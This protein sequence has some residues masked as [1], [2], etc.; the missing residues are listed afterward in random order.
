MLAEI[1]LGEEERDEIGVAAFDVEGEAEGPG[2]GA[3]VLGDDGELVAREGGRFGKTE[4]VG[5]AGRESGEIFL[6]ALRETGGVATGEADDQVGLSIVGLMES[7]EVGEFHGGERGGGAEVFV[8]VGVAGVDEVV[9]DFFAEFLV[10][11]AAQRDAEGIESVVAEAVEIVSA[12]ARMKDHIAHEGVELVEVIE[13]GLADEG[14]HFLI[15]IGPR[16]WWP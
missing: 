16:R 2:D 4:V 3:G 8:A 9:E 11:V 7:L 13:V 15:G 12:P 14:G 6:H 10:V 5:R 1:A